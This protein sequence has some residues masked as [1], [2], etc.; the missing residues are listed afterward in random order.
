MKQVT[1]ID[2]FENHIQIRLLTNGNSHFWLISVKILKLLSRHN[3]NL[4]LE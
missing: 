4:I 1:C 2:E 3:K